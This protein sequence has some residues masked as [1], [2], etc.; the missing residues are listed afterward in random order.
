MHLYLAITGVGLNLAGA[1][2]LALA[3]VWF[4]RSVLVYLDAVE[5][6]LAKVVEVLQSGGKDFIIPGVDLRRDRGQNQARSLKLVGW[7]VLALGFLLLLIA[8][9][10]GMTAWQ[11]S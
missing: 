2:I 9:R 6:N 1:L 7:G 5:A 4:S 10:F 11:A 3:D 8:L